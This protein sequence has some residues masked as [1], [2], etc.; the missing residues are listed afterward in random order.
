MRRFD[1]DQQ[2]K[3]RY[4]TEQNIEVTQSIRVTCDEC[5]SSYRLHEFVDDEGCDH[6]ATAYDESPTSDTSGSTQ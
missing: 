3:H 5:G 6:A 1:S 4:S 2:Q